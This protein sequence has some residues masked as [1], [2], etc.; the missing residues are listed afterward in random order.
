[1]P[2]GLTVRS[3]ALLRLG[4]VPPYVF[5]YVPVGA[6]FWLASEASY[7]PPPPP[8]AG[9][10]TVFGTVLGSSSPPCRA[11]WLG[12]PRLSRTACYPLG[13]TALPWG[14]GL[15]L[16][17]FALAVLCS[18]GTARHAQPLAPAACIAAPIPTW[19]RTS[20]LPRMHGVQRKSLLRGRANCRQLVRLP[21]HGRERSAQRPGVRPGPGAIL[22]RMLRHRPRTVALPR[23]RRCRGARAP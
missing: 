4:L 7:V 6:P 8:Q 5:L 22:R 21:G 17:R 20:P 23:T 18:P 16:H 2:G 11:N 19:C 10:L 12:P 3:L 9:G 1:M 15:W 14:C 13:G